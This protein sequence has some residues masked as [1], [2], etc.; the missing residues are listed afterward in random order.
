MSNPT[1]PLADLLPL[2]LP[3][4]LGCADMVASFNLRQAAIEFCEKTLCWRHITTQ[5]VIANE[6]VMVAPSY[7]TIHKI[8]DAEWGGNKLTPIAYTVLSPDAKAHLGSPIYVTQTEPN[9]VTL[10][11]FSAGEL[12]ISVF[13]KPTQGKDWT[14]N[15]DHGLIDQFDQIPE[16][17]LHQYGEILAEGALGRILSQKGTDYYDANR[18]AYYLSRFS[19]R[20]GNLQGSSFTGQ[21]RAPRRTI[22]SFI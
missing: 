20:A 6:T 3:H 9:G 22:P 4:A 16:F 17:M 5:A 12:T 8:E 13:L 15:A 19:E 14:Q 11:P 2:V 1:R 7:A 21:Q 10:V 18:A